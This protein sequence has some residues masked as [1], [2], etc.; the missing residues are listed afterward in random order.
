ME[1]L[2]AQ[3]V[4]LSDLVFNLIAHHQVHTGASGQM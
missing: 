4:A 3:C 1:A 2:Q